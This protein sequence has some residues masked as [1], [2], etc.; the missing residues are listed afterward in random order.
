[1]EIRSPGGFVFGIQGWNYGEIRPRTITFFIDG[2][3]K[4]SDHHGNA[5][6]E[7]TGS[8]K[9]V[10]AKL[11]EQGVDWQKI[12]ATGWPQL[13]YAELKEL[14]NVPPTPLDELVKIKNKELR[15]DAIKFRKEADV[16]AQAAAEAS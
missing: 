9:E 3:T 15:M 7:F 8:H 13:P 10:I 12:D 4:V 1:M 6:P 16:A 5:I 14:V 2:T 11:K